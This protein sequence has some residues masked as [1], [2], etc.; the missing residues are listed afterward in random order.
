MHESS[1]AVARR[2]HTPGF[3][4]RYFVGSGIDVGC[5]TDPLSQLAV[6]F[7]GIQ[8]VVDHDIPQGDAQLLIEYPDASFDFLHSSHCL[9]HLADPF[10]ALRNWV[11]VVRPGG[12]LVILV[13]DEDLYEQGCWPSRFNGDH[14]WTFTLS[15]RSSWSPRSINVFTL[16]ESVNDSAQPIKVELLHNTCFPIQSGVDQTRNMVTEAAIEFILRV[17]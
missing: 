16:L 15:K 11:R 8:H 17:L 5:G 2:L 10:E 4:T 14:K 13:P 9:E 1:K 12:H 6:L 3:A 7:P